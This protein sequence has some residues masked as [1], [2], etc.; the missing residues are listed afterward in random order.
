MRLLYFYCCS[1]CYCCHCCCCYYYYYYYYYCCHCWWWED[2]HVQNEQRGIRPPPSE[3]VHALSLKS[4]GALPL[5]VL[6]ILQQP[7]TILPCAF[8]SCCRPFLVLVRMAAIGVKFETMNSRLVTQR[9]N[10]QEHTM[11]M[12]KQ[13]MTHWLH[14]CVG[15]VDP[16]RFVV[17]APRGHIFI[18][19]FW[20]SIGDRDHNLLSSTSISP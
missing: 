11:M 3:F 9:T 7:Q 17:F 20:G 8:V 12:T 2:Q 1:Y 6:L 19:I 18:A 15:C 4:V 5:L 13:A 14:I 10:K 16:C